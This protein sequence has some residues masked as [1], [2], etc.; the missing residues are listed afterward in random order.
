MK[1]IEELKLIFKEAEHDNF[2]KAVCDYLIMKDDKK[3]NTVWIFGHTDTGKTTFKDKMLE[4]F[5]CAEYKETKGIFDCVYKNSRVGPAFI[6]VDEG[7]QRT[8][9]SCNDSYRIAKKFLGG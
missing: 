1:P 2:V 7:A 4:I 5:P 3:K 8:F 6:L 9:F